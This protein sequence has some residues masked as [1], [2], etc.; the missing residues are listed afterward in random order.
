MG[1]GKKSKATRDHKRTMGEGLVEK[2]YEGG[3]VHKPSSFLK[4]L[5]PSQPVLKKKYV[6]LM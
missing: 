6:S 2:I 4:D 1:L 3:M 5:R